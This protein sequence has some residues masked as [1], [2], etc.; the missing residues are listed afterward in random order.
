MDAMFK[1]SDPSVDSKT[2]T[3]WEPSSDNAFVMRD[4]QHGLNMDLMTYSMFTLANK[5]PEALLNYSTLVGH[6]NRTFQTF[7]QHFVNNGL[8]LTDGGLAF[9][10]ISDRRYESLG[11]PVHFNGTAL[12]ARR[13]AELNTNRTSEAWISIRVKALHMNAIATYLSV[14]ILIWLV[15]TTVVMACLQRRYTSSMVRDVHL[16]ADVLVLIAGSEN[17]LQLVHERDVSLER[18]EGIKTMLGWFKS[19]D[20]EIRWGVEIVGERSTVEWVDA[21]KQGWHVENKH[22]AKKKQKGSRKSSH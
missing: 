4:R 22:T 13:Y 2:R 14:A 7:F 11:R 20:D 5:D 16:I 19:K 3:Y 18:D 10:S 6:A 9:Q 21:P 1:A 8:S 12:P 17:L 15:A